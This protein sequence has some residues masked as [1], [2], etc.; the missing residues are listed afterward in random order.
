M[1]KIL[2]ILAVVASATAF[3]GPSVQ[4]EYTDE[5]NDTNN[6]TSAVY[7]LTVKNQFAKG[8]Y[9]DIGG[10]TTQQDGTKTLSQRLEAGVTYEPLSWVYVRGAV[11]EKFSNGS[12]NAYYSIEPGLKFPVAANLTGKVAYRYRNA[13]D[14]DKF[15]TQEENTYRVGLTYA[16]TPQSALGVGYDYTNG[17]VEK[18]AWKL[19]Y[20]HSF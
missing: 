5:K 19:N 15:N 4:V 10:T 3:A 8:W 7:G 6:T 17:D 14:V 12:S 9:G 2:A 16:V 13:F 1:K 20:T 11:G 18:K